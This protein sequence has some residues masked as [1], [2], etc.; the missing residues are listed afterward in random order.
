MD[1]NP[2]K[3]FSQGYVMRTTTKHMRKDVD[4]SIR[5]TFE[6]VAEFNNDP[7]KSQEV[8][9]TLSALHILRKMID[10]FQ[11]HNQPIFKE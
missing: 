8:L 10:D 9:Q 6:R 4:V 3:K 11:L 1:I 7:V 5:K 2:D